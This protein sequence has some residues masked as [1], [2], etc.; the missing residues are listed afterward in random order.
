MSIQERH[1]GDPHLNEQEFTKAAERR[2]AIER[3][4]HPVPD[5]DPDYGLDDAAEEAS[6][7]HDTTPEPDAEV[8]VSQ[9]SARDQIAQAR[10]ALEDTRSSISER[11]D[12]SSSSKV[13]NEDDF[14]ENGN[15]KP[16]W[17]NK[18]AQ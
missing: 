5:L 15:L 7:A 9:T 17:Y 2:A 10:A 1:G 11:P 13:P 16:E 8:Q 18:R 4:L 14:D 12:T 3:H 6:S